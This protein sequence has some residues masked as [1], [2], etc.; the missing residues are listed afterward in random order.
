[1]RDPCVLRSAE[2]TQE[3]DGAGATVRGGPTEPESYPQMACDDRHDDQITSL[4]HE[5]PRHRR[6]RL[7]RI[8]HRP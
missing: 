5:V 6:R 3:A 4:K 1:L 7:H 8:A 2:A